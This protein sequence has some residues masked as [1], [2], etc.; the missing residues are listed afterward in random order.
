MI[1]SKLED[2]N[3]YPNPITGNGFIA[4]N[5]LEATEQ[6]IS[7]YDIAGRVVYEKTYAIKQGENKLTLETTNLTKG[8]YFIHLADGA[9]GVNIKF[10]KE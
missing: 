9:E 3:I 4:F 7:I 10:I 1:K 2:V 5:S 8:M 6:L